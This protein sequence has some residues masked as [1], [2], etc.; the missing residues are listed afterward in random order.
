MTNG[1][2][3]AVQTMQAT[4]GCPPRDGTHAETGIQQLCSCHHSVLPSSDLG[5]P[6]IPPGD[7]FPHSGNKSPVRLVL[8]LAGLD[9]PGARHEAADTSG[10]L[11]IDV[12][13]RA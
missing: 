11:G 1:V 12:T 5:Y 9:Q 4:L 2:Y 8:P 6:P 7:F 3:A 10:V 13:V